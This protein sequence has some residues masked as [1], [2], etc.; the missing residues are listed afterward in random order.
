MRRKTLHVCRNKWDRTYDIDVSFKRG[1]HKRNW[2]PMLERIGI[3]TFCG[4]RVHTLDKLTT[5][6]EATCETCKEN[7]ALDLLANI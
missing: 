4:L 1:Y 2:R 3:V 5:L 6:K 7:A